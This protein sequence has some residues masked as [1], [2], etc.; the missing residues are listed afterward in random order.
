MENTQ[1]LSLTAGQR[2]LFEHLC[3]RR[4]R[5]LAP[6]TLDQLCSELGLSSR[7]SLHK[8]VSALI[9]AGLVEPMDGK[10]RGVR[11]RALAPMA[12]A[13]NDDTLPLLGKIAA[14]R[15]IDA[16]SGAERVQVPA[17]MRPRGEGYALT[18]QGDSMRDA[19]IQD[20]DVVII[21]AREHARPGEIVVALIDGESATLK[22]LRPRGGWIELE[23]EN[24]EHPTQRYAPERVQVQGVVVGLMRRYV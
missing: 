21:E 24:P 12:T 20:G 6:A 19:G 16:L 8:Q 22:R 9:D 5:G 17:A 14:G 13:E 4:A 1:A 15:P 2:Q 11:L 23:S 10:Q 18:V 7:G 3:E